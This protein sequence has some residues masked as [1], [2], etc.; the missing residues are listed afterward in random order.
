MEFLG[1]QQMIEV[2]F[3]IFFNKDVYIFGGFGIDAKDYT[4]I[5]F[6]LIIGI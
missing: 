1:F 4:G 5:K 6:T 3:F 2:F